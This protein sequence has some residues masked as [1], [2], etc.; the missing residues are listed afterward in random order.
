MILIHR[1]IILI[2]EVLQTFKLN[3]YNYN[4]TQR[5]SWKTSDKTDQSILIIHLKRRTILMEDHE[6]QTT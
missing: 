5:I 3:S 6:K 4:I 1:R 2:Y